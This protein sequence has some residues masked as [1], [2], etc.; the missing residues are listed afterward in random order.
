MANLKALLTSKKFIVL[1][2]LTAL[3][4]VLGALRLAA[5]A[6]VTSAVSTIGAAFLVAQGAADF[7]KAKE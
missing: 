5:W 2:G 3:F 1:L 7:G 4:I 6:D